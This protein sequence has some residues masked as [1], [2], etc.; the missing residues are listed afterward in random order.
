MEELKNKTVLIV[1]DDSRNI[2]ALRSYL[3]TLEMKIL[4][5][6]NGEQALSMLHEGTIPDL[7]IMDMM[8]PVMD[9]YETVSILKADNSFN[10]IPVIAV[11]ARA[12]KGDREKC[13]Q[14]GAWDYISKPVDIGGL[15]KII[16]KWIV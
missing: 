8:M 16:K 5:A 12:M 15:L 7:I 4:T 2:F 10:R 13:L 1:D 9:G 14:A 11:T 6:G 3:E